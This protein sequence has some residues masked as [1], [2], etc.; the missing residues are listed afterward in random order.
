MGAFYAAAL[1]MSAATPCL[2]AV[3]VSDSFDGSSESALSE[4]TAVMSPGVVA[5]GGSAEWVANGAFYAA[6]NVGFT[7]GSGLA[8]LSLG[9]YIWNAKGTEDALFTLTA[10]LAITSGTWI[11]VGF[12]HTD[13]PTNSYFS[14]GISGN[15]GPG[16]ATSILRRTD[17]GDNYY[18]GKGVGGAS[19]PGVITGPVTFTIQVDLRSWNG[20]TDWGTVTFTNVN[21]SNVSV[22]APRTANLPDDLDENPFKYVGFSGNTAANG[23]IS[24]FTLSQIPEPSAMLLMFAAPVLVG[25]SRRR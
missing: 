25:F 1:T 23:S 5:A 4:R 13:A 15:P 19:N 20:S 14:N 2:G 7:S 8:R 6:G 12:F 10:T 16:M 22:G 11:S 21:S 24:N 3:I 9:D 18:S 17:A